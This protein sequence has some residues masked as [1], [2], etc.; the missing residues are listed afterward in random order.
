MIGKHAHKWGSSTKKPISQSYVQDSEAVILKASWKSS[1]QVTV[2]ILPMSA[3]KFKWRI[4]KTPQETEHV[5]LGCPW[6]CRN[7]CNQYSSS[8]EPCLNLQ[9]N[10]PALYCITFATTWSMKNTLRKTPVPTWPTPLDGVF[11]DFQLDLWHSKGQQWT[12]KTYT[13]CLQQV[14]R[15]ISKFNFSIQTSLTTTLLKQFSGCRPSQLDPWALLIFLRC[16]MHLKASH[17]SACAVQ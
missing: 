8:I 3:P 10:P 9:G 17:C 7:T 1:S 12:I 11:N 15:L 13:K 14:L 2:I 6:M 16:R 4:V 5:K